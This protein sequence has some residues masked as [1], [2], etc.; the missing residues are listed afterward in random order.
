MNLETTLTTK[1]EELQKLQAAETAATQQLLAK[2]R[3]LRAE[4]AEIEKEI[5]KLKPAD[6]K[7][8]DETLTS[9]GFREDGNDENVI[10]YR[11][12]YPAPHNSFYDYI[13]VTYEE[14]YDDDT[15]EYT[16]TDL[17]S[18]RYTL[19]SDYNDDIVEEDFDTFAELL[20]FYVS[21]RQI[22]TTVTISFTGT[23]QVSIMSGVEDFDPSLMRSIAGEIYDALTAHADNEEFS[24]NIDTLLSIEFNSDIKIFNSDIKISGA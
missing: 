2:Q 19:N 1:Q 7:Y 16:N 21:E 24:E 15:D 12:D 13:Q 5:K 23:A 22:P 18:I 3:T 20:A 11:K 8:I 14:D 10:Y 9:M 17:E 6:S 4:I